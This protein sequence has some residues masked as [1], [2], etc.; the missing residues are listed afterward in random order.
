MD[1]FESVSKQKN[2]F[3]VNGKLKEPTHKD[4]QA[5]EGTMPAFTRQ[6]EG[7]R[8]VP[9]E[10]FFSGSAVASAGSPEAYDLRALFL[11]AVLFDVLELL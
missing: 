5:G 11:L 4:H 6:T 3:H 2:R 1:P 7:H 9:S 10:H 8:T